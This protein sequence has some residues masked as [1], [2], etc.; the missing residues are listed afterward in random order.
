[1]PGMRVHAM[2]IT[3]F[4][5]AG[6]V[7]WKLFRAHLQF[8]A[9]ADIGVYIASQGSGEG[10]LL[11]AVEKVELFQT[12]ADELGGT[13]PVVAAGIGLAGSTRDAIELVQ[14]A[15]AA[16]AD[17]VQLLGPRPGPLP[18]RPAE[19]ETYLRTLI[20]AAECD[21]HLSSNAVLTGYPLPFEMVEALVAAE[22]RVRVL[23][24]TDRDRDAMLAYVARAVETFGERVEVRIG[25]TSEFVRAHEVGAQGLLCFEP[26]VAPQLAVAA[27]AS[28]QIDRLMQLNTALARGGN[29]RSLKAALTL[30]GRDGGELRAPYLPLPADEMDA[31]RAELRALDLG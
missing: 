30:L 28:L 29:P 27:G 22:E 26:N 11:S 31:L 5:K 23:N 6:P 14:R 24:V 3:P 20:D 8:L 13:R 16:G 4:T 7:D 15:S 19:I 1:M 21:V 25:V 18:P 10:D 12:A 2:S 17:A 9:A